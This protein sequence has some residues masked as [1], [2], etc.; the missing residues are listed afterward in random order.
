MRL[1]VLALI[2]LG[3][4]WVIAW[5][6]I[7]REPAESVL[8][9]TPDANET[10]PPYAT[11]EIVEIARPPRP[12]PEAPAAEPPDEA[13]AVLPVEPQ[14]EAPPW[15]VEGSFATYEITST[16]PAEDGEGG[17][18]TSVRIRH[19][20]AD[21]MWRAACKET[22]E[23]RVSLMREEDD[24]KSTRYRN[25]TT[26]RVFNDAP[27]RAPNVTAPGQRVS[28]PIYASCGTTEVVAEVAQGDAS[29]SWTANA[30]GVT[31]TWDASRHLVTEWRTKAGDEEGHGRL[32][33]T[34][35]DVATSPPSPS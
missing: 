4:A 24:G 35:A 18:N 8:N 15:P 5:D 1:A 34:D 32:V 12:P 3:V 10:V 31:I 16:D 22:R 14:V 19:V 20:Y 28:I 2:L 29:T 23:E 17:E 6:S 13:E 11:P 9:E 25:V 27:P 33:D 7:P 26:T 30:T 21:G